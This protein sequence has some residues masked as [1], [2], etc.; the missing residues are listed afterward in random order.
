[1]GPLDLLLHLLNFIAPAAGMAAGI[2]LMARLFLKKQSRTPGWPVQ[3]AINFAA[4]LAV[5]VAGLVL[6]G[7]DG[8]M[9]TYAALAAVVA[10]SQWVVGRYWR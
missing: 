3:A 7:R 5:L 2:T 9:A 10:A 1:M 4:G 8:K 6:F